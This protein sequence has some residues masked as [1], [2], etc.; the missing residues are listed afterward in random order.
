MMG[1]PLIA[2][3]PVRN[4]ESV[5]NTPLRKWKTDSFE[6][7]IRTPLIAHWPSGIKPQKDWNRDPVHLID[8]MPRVVAISMDAE[9]LAWW[10]DCTGKAWTGPPPKEKAD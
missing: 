6:E 2:S 4:S 8:I 5:C 9:W 1:S 3:H 7:G 10:K